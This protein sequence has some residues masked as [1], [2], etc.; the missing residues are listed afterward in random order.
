MSPVP[1]PHDS[2]AAEVI[3]VESYFGVD[4]RHHLGLPPT[5]ATYTVFVW[6]DEIV[7]ELQTVQIPRGAG[8]PRASKAVLHAPVEFRPPF[9]A[10]SDLPLLEQRAGRGFGIVPFNDGGKL[11][12]L[13]FDFRSRELAAMSIALPARQGAGAV[14]F[15]FDI[16]SLL[17]PG[18]LDAPEPPNRLFL[19][20]VASGE[21]S[22][23]LVIEP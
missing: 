23:V 19:L 10:T 2:D 18:F 6:L 14:G 20:S 8:E 11:V 13:A 22:N 1:L 16:H 21:A 17:Q 7:S 5:A 3:A 12:L 15:E 4:L 9:P